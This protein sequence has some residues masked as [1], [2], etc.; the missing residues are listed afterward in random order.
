MDAVQAIT[1]ALGASWASGINLYATAVVLGGLNLFGIVDLPP[2]MEVLSSPMVLGAAALM[3]GVEFFAD[4]IPGVDS[5]WDIIHTFVRIPAGAMLAAGAVGGLDTGTIGE[6]ETIAA[7]VTGGAVAGVSHTTKAASRAV[8]N[9][10]P[11]PFTNWAASIGED[12]MVF[13][14][15]SFALFNPV[16]FL[17]GLA[18][19]AL[20]L[21]WLIPKIWRGLRRFVGSFKHPIDNAKEVRAGVGS[22]AGSGV[23]AE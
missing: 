16:Y 9:T 21:I 11:E 6:I 19:F 8:I 23:Q 1:L 7:M 22:E 3:Y 2:E 10:S 14:G 13:T 12:I 20:L 4:K 18:I 17:V 15:L 5:L